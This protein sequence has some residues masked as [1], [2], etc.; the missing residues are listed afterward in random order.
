MAQPHIRDAPPPVQQPQQP[1]PQQQY[2][3]ERH[4][5]EP[6]A[7]AGA[8]QEADAAAPDAAAAAAAAAAAGEEP[9]CWVP[10]V[11]RCRWR[12]APAQRRLL[13]R[14]RANLRA[15][16]VAALILASEWAGRMSRRGQQTDGGLGC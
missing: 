4:L 14:L 12:R 5:E 16:A 2:P 8:A 1:P 3:A 7:A 13:P 10:D 6:P 15:M 11:M 9:P